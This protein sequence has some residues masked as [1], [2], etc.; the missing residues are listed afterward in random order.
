[1]TSPT[2]YSKKLQDL[3]RQLFQFDCADLDFGIYRI[4]NFKR[5]VLDKF[6]EKDLPRAVSAELDTGA[7]SEQSE[8]VE[9]LKEVA[10]Q[11]R[12][13]LGDDAIDGDGN[14]A[15][16]H[17][18]TKVG[19]K[20]LALQARVGGAQ[21]RPALEAAVFNHLYSFFSRY[22][23]AGDFMSKRRYSKKEK[24]A[25]PYNGEEVYLH[26]ANKDQYY[27]KTGEYF[28]DYRFSAPNGV[29]VHF[30]IQAADVEKENIKGENRFFIPLAKKAAFDSKTKEIILP[31]EYRPLTEQEDVKYGTRNQQE[32]IIAEALEAVPK[33]FSK[34]DTALAA[35]IAERRKTSD[36]QSVSYFE[37][38]LR[39]YS[40]RN[41]SDFFIHKD[42]KGFLTRE[43]DFYLK[44]EVLGLDEM[45]AA[46]ESRAAGWFQLIHT[47]RSIGRTIIAFL[48]QI[49]DFQKKLFE[50]R[51]FI[52]ESQYC[53]TV[54]NIAEEFYPDIAACESQWQEWKYLFKIEEED[55]RL[56]GAAKNKTALRIAFLKANPT[57]V[58]D[59]KYFDGIFLDRL[60]ASF[61]NLDE[62]TNGL[63]IHS[64]NFQ[65]LNTLSHKYRSIIKCVY[66]D[67]PFNTGTNDFLYKNDYLNSSWLSM[68][69]GRILA[70]RDFLSNDANFFCRIDHHGDYLVRQILA[71]VFSEQRYQN[72]I[73]LKRGRE[74]AGTRGKLEIASETLFWYSVGDNPIFNELSIDRSIA[75]VQWTAFLMGGERHPRERTFM[76]K[77]LI[78]PDGQHYSL[79]QPKVDKLLE[80]HFLRLRCSKCGA[81]YFYA[82]SDIKLHREMK[83]KLN[84]YKYYDITPGKV[85]HG[86]LA[87]KKCLE[88]GEDDWRVD[89]LGA[90]TVNLSN[91]W[92]DI[93]SYAKTT[94]FFTENSEA[95]LR[96]VI[97]LSTNAKEWVMDYFL[98]S[99]T[100]T[101]V[102]H[103]I[104]R[105][106]IGIEMG[107]YFRSIPLTRMKTVLAGNNRGISGEISW[108]GGGILK[109][110]ELETYEDSLNNIAFDEEMGQQ[111]LQFDDYL[112]DYMLDWET[113]G[114]ETFLNIEKLAS[115]FDYK[116]RV[117]QDGQ[118]GEKAVDLPETFNYLLGLHVTTR[119]VYYDKDRRY[120]VYRG[121]VD[122][123][124]ICAIWRTTAGWGK[125]D[126]ERDKKFVAE[127]K[128]AEG[129]D[130][131]FVNSDSVIPGA[132]S[133]DPV[134][135]ARMFAP[136]ASNG[137]Y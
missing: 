36:G 79:A 43:L 63:L 5:A 13:N 129:A 101:A 58:I 93:E 128:I 62:A 125:E 33:H 19:R 46:G 1:M 82:E 90:P 84:R 103:K 115:P 6:I 57:L 9:Q 124:Q 94:G 78:P 27:I 31:F 120:L 112:V 110:H 40:R 89:Y 23:D 77:T 39:Q 7:L 99:G 109:Y 18:D 111:A 24:Y 130:E 73:V 3:L 52:L 38:H 137:A 100:T 37:H 122:S 86:V 117:T 51:K 67:P 108:T 17:G 29:A 41:T 85:V 44:N 48:S 68:L 96:R 95:L 80:E 25:V 114:N 65:G 87:I 64:E 81:I 69:Y 106:Y 88:C 134:F 83:K 76:G 42:L 131:I 49:E 2:D 10:K 102:A 91:L 26:W 105:K 71:K 136:I 123:R 113:R 11:I 54:G 98:G 74:T 47:L 127:Q 56:F 61:G 35:L 50:K 55:K 8:V 104:G 28:A 66:I 107:E 72:Q 34:E 32:A 121:T 135:K 75:D 12:E 59:T 14:L 60:L 133:L 20:Y 116:L 4:M 53:I 132:R 45:E 16:K 22:Y 97:E 70:S 30:K 92:I 119:K 118:T 21:S 15:P 126:F